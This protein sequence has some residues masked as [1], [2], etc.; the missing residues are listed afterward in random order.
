MATAQPSEAHSLRVTA[1]VPV[2]YTRL[3]SKIEGLLQKRK[4]G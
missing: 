2:E 3:L 4:A 1:A